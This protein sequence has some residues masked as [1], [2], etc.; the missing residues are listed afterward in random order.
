MALGGGRMHNMGMAHHHDPLARH[1]HD[2]GVVGEALEP[3]IMMSADFE[4]YKIKAQY[5]TQALI[6]EKSFATEESLIEVLIRIVIEMSGEQGLSKS[7]N[8]LRQAELEQS[9]SKPVS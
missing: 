9:N 3:Y 2:V 6:T 5:R 4:I 1:N 8:K 7:S